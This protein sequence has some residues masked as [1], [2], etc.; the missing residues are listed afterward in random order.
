MA[1]IYAGILGL[2]A[3]LTCLARGALHAWAAEKALLVAWTSL[4]VFAGLGSLIGWI[5][6]R[7]IEE[8]AHGRIAAGSD[9]AKPA[10][11]TPRA[12]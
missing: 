11:Q 5:A 7:I 6:E 1:R 10:P 2:V 3:F 12:P 9:A 8:D 4:L